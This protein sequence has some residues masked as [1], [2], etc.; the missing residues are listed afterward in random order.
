MKNIL[1][2]LIASCILAACDKKLDISPS[3]AIPGDQAF[4]TDENVKKALNGAYDAMTT[5][6]LLNGDLQLYSELLGADGEITWTGTYGQPRQIFEKQILVNN[7]Y[8]ASTWDNAY[9]AINICNNIL[10]AIDV[11][12]P[13]DQDRVK[14]EALFIRG[15]MYFELVRFFGKPY[16][17]GDVNTNLGVQ[18][19]TTPTKG[20]I[21]EAN[22]VP[23]STVAE[24][25]DRVL[26]DLTE[27]ESL[28]P[29]ENG[30]YATKYAAAAI[31]SRVYLQ[32]EDF[33]KARDEANTVI[34]SGEYSL[35]STYA[36]AFNNDENS[37]EDIFAV[38]VSEQ[39]GSNDFNLFW[40]I[41][42]Y[43][44]RSGDVDIEQ[45]HLDLYEPD[46]ARLALFYEDPHHVWRSGKWQQYAKN[47]PIVR[48]GEM[49][50]TRAECNFRL[51]TSVGATP[52]EDIETIRARSGLS[53]TQSYI[54][55]NNIIME[56]HLEIAHE[57]ERI[58][59][60]KRLRQS[61][62][63]YDYDANE[64]VLPIPINQI[65]IVGKDILKQNDG[66]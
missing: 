43:G 21:T 17:A 53:T 66:Y 58:H 35:T 60:V 45:K 10:D 40:S 22:Y 31:L 42:Q 5:D 11:V 4:S 3:D 59:D 28:L 57:G 33:A 62:D 39:D 8:V 56:R 63:G 61:V 46:D 15:E 41:P 23:R 32:M 50:V 47:I 54:T 48:L 51:G 65:I 26:N 49:Y 2:I 20:S 16:S 9:A 1:Y 29:E 30:F 7:D 37:S 18:I 27:A 19:V 24:T 12:K 44:G 55:L 64:L 52:F 6:Y 25:Y 36:E 13:E 14:G 38:Q 34:E